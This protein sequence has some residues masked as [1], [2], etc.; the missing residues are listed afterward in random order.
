MMLFGY[1]TSPLNRT[2]FGTY[3]KVSWSGSSSPQ[4]PLQRNTSPLQHSLRRTRINGLMLVFSPLTQRTLLV[5]SEAGISSQFVHAYCPRVLSTLNHVP[6]GLHSITC[7]SENCTVTAIQSSKLLHPPSNLTRF[8]F[9][10]TFR[11]FVEALIQVSNF[12]NQYPPCTLTE[13][14][15]QDANFAASG[16]LNYGRA[17][18]RNV[19]ASDFA[20]R[21]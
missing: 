6:L 21:F 19:S 20:L 10:T 4:K 3:L 15:I 5:H 16:L 9:A 13:L 12:T 1:W 18:L 14:C 17:D 8:A 11:Q 2:A 7:V